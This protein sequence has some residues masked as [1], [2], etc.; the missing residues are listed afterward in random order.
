MKMTVT[1]LSWPL[2]VLAVG[3]VI[4]LVDGPTRFDCMRGSKPACD[5]IDAKYTKQPARLPKLTGITTGK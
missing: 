4:W 2:F 5:Y 1:N 3:L